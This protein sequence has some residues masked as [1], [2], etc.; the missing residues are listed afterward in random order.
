M[1]KTLI[2]AILKQAFTKGIGKVWE[3]KDMLSL[4]W[5]TLFGRYKKERIRFSISYLFRI[6]IPGTN[7]YLLVLNRR[8]QNQLQ[9]VGGAYKR[10]GDDKLFES[11]EFAPDTRRN[12][13]GIDGISDGDLRFTVPGRNVIKIIKWFEE[14]REREISGEREFKEE[15]IDQDILDKDA[16]ASI[17]YRHIRRV[18][19]NLRY[20]EFHQCYEVLIYDILELLPDQKQKDFLTNLSKIPFDLKNKYAI[21]ECEDIEQLRL[22]KNGHQAAKIGEHTKLIINQNF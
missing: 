1:F 15:L 4:Y 9:P 22:V 20:S 8:I 18:S 10:Y 13:I 12:G 3:N 7:S 2:A 5:K 6:K 11:L 16:F 14:G 19:K 17:K 21:A